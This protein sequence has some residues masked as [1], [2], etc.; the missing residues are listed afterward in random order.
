MKRTRFASLL[1]LLSLGVGLALLPG[2]STTQAQE[3][4][5]AGLIALLPS[6][7]NDAKGKS[8][9]TPEAVKGKIVGLY[10]SAHWC[11]PCRA[12]TPSLVDFRN[13]NSEHFEI[14]F[15]S[16]DH[17]EKE[18]KEYIREARMKWYSVDGVRS[19]DGQALAAKYSVSGIP[20]LVILAPDGSTITEQGRADVSQDPKGALAKWQAAIK[21][22]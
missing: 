11:P 19:K 22:S 10:F 8:V 12:F 4:D 14:I 16:H 5:S 20:K 9:P 13:D 17:S 6:K 18:K 21:K 1:T 7:L 2:I 3:S 15:V